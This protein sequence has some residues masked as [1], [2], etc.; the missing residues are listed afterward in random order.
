MS[1]LADPSRSSVREP[2]IPR[3]PPPAERTQ[4]RGAL[5][6]LGVAAICLVGFVIGIRS[7]VRRMPP[8]P[9]AASAAAADSARR[10]SL[11]RPRF[12]PPPTNTPDEYPRLR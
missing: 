3:D 7:A 5:I 11:R 12:T 9:T 1:N 6:A 8:E 4:A 10:D 2:T